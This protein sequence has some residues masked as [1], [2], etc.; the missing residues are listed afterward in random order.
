MLFINRLVSAFLLA[1]LSTLS[2][3][4]SN[5][6]LP[7]KYILTNPPPSELHVYKIPTIHESAILARRILMLS[8]ITSLSTM[9]PRSS[10]VLPDHNPARPLPAALQRQQQPLSHQYP[11]NL[12]ISGLPIGL[13]DYYASCAQ[14]PW[15]PTLLALNIATTF[16]NTHAGSNVSFSLRWHPPANHP[17]SSNPYT[18]SAANMPR[19]SL[20]GYVEAIPAKE[21]KED[22]IEACFLSKHAEAKAWSPGNQIHESWWARLVV[23][24]VYWVGGFGDRAFIGWI[25]AEEWEGVTSEEVERARL[26]GEEGYD[27]MGP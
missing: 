24:G 12:D 27:A 19:F 23:Q 3:A 4:G 5:T 9:F 14:R 2:L 11:P 26:V 22:D 10:S 8:S 7:L 25:P 16:R 20:E 17:P 15:S 21:V 6:L 13:M 1:L 18:Y